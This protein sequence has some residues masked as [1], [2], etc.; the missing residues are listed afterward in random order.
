MVGWFD[1]RQLFTTGIQVVVST[2]F[3]RHSDARLLEALA[4]AGDEDCFDY[5]RQGA[6]PREELWIDYVADAGDGWDSTYAVA[7]WLTRPELLAECAAGERVATRRGELLILGGDQVYPTASRSAYQRRLIA[8]YETAR[9]RAHPPAPHAFAIPGNHDWYDSLVSFTRLFCGGRR[10]AAWRTRQRRSYF[11]LRLPHGWWLA[12][13]DLQLGSDIDALQVAYFRK[14]AVGMHPGDRVILCTA[15]PEW[16]YS[17]TYNELDPTIDE[18]NVAYLETLFA[19][20][21]AQV[22]V[23]LAGDLHHYRRHESETGAQKIT[24]GGG[25]AFLH[26]THGP[27]VEALSGGYRLVAAFPQPKL[28]RALAWR[29]LAFPWINPRFGVLTGA[30]YALLGWWAEPGGLGPIVGPLCVVAGFVLFTDTHSK[31]Y[32][33]IAGSLHGAAHV[34]TAFTLAAWSSPL[35]DRTA[36]VLVGYVPLRELIRG[37]FLFAGGWLIG[38]LLMGAYLLVSLN[39]FGR[40][41]NEAFSSLR[42]PDFKNFLRLHVRPDGALAIYPFGIARVPRRWKPNPDATA[43]DARLVPDDPHATPAAAI[44]VI[45]V[46]HRRDG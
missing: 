26:P 5:T 3:G 18:H 31:W 19:A 2:L 1:P 35:V 16:I 21:G 25:G 30:V 17:S 45:L 46:K 40:H 32:R 28:S 34:A 9:R 22:V 14:A 43:Y 15:L 27:D 6:L 44:E 37:A 38:S 7:Y 8:A 4:A 33:R 13:A 10:F 20:R 12:G 42:I 36:S 39:V 11:L 41:S 24:A 29:N 23:H